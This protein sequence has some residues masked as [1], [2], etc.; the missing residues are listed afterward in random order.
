MTALWR[1][2]DSQRKWRCHCQLWCHAQD[3]A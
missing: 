1:Q 2:C 3:L